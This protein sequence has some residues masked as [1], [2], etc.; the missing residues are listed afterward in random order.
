MRLSLRLSLSLGGVRN[1][2]R[3]R[4]RSQVK[5]LVSQ[6]LHGSHPLPHALLAPPTVHDAW[7]TAAPYQGVAVVLL[8]SLAE[9]G[10]LFAGCDVMGSDQGVEY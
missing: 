7:S 8:G 2:Y 6:P 9:V 3:G 5:V 4:L 1:V 10:Y